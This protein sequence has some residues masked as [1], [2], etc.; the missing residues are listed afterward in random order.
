MF[1]ILSK[2]P[3]LSDRSPTSKASCNVWWD[4]G[5]ARWW[6]WHQLFQEQRICFKPCKR[7]SQLLRRED[8]LLPSLELWVILIHLEWGRNGTGDAGEWVGSPSKGVVTMISIN[9]NLAK[10]PALFPQSSQK[11]NT[12]SRLRRCQRKIWGTGQQQFLLHQLRWTISACSHCSL[13]WD[14]LNSMPQHITNVQWPP[15]ARCIWAS[16][17]QEHPRPLDFSQA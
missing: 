3:M 2:R 10:T 15:L 13:W 11:K 12:K 9:K 14:Y 4:L 5:F 8:R 17:A 1:N 6:V 16:S 7:S